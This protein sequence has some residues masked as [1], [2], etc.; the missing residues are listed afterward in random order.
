MDNVIKIVQVSKLEVED[1]QLGEDLGEEIK[2]APT[3]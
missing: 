2:S 3:I 1:I